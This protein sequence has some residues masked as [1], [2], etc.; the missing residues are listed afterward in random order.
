[1]QALQED[2]NVAL[3]I[4]LVDGM[5]KLLMKAVRMIIWTTP[6]GIGS[7]ICGSIV[8]YAGASTIS[9]MIGIYVLTI[10]SGLA[11]H[12]FGILPVAYYFI[13]RNNPFRLYSGL[14]LLS[15]PL[16]GLLHQPQRF[17]K[18]CSVLKKT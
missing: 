8:K 1:M 7:L 3:V 17:L 16:L 15:L 13:T 4:R 14:A 11:I 9:K 2:E 10:L 5:N 12:A 6:L 18:Q